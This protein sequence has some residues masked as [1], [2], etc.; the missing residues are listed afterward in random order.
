MD[1]ADLVLLGLCGARRLTHFDALINIS[2]PSTGNG[3]RTEF[4]LATSVVGG[5][6]GAAVPPG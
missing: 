1:R 6:Q 5:G 3:N 4:M 2:I